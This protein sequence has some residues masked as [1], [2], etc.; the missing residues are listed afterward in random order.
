MLLT[1]IGKIVLTLLAIAIPLN[2][3][4]LVVH[5]DHSNPFGK[6]LDSICGLAWFFG[7][8]CTS[9]FLILKIWS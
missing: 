9:I 7:A 2:L 6:F 5:Y 8:I 3:M 1:I 4:M